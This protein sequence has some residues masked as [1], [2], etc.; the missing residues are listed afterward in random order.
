M[1][2]GIFAMRFDHYVMWFRLY[3]FL[4]SLLIPSSS[5]QALLAIT[6]WLNWVLNGSQFLL[7]LGV[8]DKKQAETSNDTYYVFRG[9]NIHNKRFVARELDGQKSEIYLCSQGCVRETRLLITATKRDKVYRSG[10]RRVSKFPMEKRLHSICY[11]R[12]FNHCKIQTSP[13]SKEKE[14]KKI[15]SLKYIRGAWL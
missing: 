13:G 12:H 1:L 3:I 8:K 7:F 15:L 10:T 14:L 4:T 5:N 2:S 11:P 6:N 9:N